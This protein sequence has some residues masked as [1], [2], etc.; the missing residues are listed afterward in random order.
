MNLDVGYKF[1]LVNVDIKLVV[2]KELKWAKFLIL[3]KQRESRKQSQKWPSS[4]P[5]IFWI[6]LIKFWTLLDNLPKS[7]FPCRNIHHKIEVVFGLAPLSKT[8]YRLNQ[9]ELKKLKRQINDLFNWGYIKTKQVALCG[10][11]CVYG[12][13]GFRKPRMCLNYHD[14]TK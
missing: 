11:Y 6:H 5:I 3:L 8:F 1:A 14:L 2:L 7:L 12:Q 10:T 9:K 13:K 4:S